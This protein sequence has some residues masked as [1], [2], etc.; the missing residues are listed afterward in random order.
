MALRETY[1]L[2]L[3]RYFSQR[4]AIPW[5]G[6]L[7]DSGSREYR[8]SAAVPTCVVTSGATLRN[9]LLAWVLTLPAAMVVSGFLFFAFRKNV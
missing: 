2:S 3:H 1:E 8:R 7:P 4:K 6:D 5:P 9:L